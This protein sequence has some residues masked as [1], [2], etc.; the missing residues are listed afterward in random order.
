MADRRSYITD[1]VFQAIK[2]ND[3]LENLDFDADYVREFIV[4]NYFQRALAHLFAQG[5][6][7]A[8]R[9]K[10][11]AAGQLEIAGGGTIIDSYYYYYY[12]A[13]TS[14]V[15]QSFPTVVQRFFL[16]FPGSRG[17]FALSN[18]GV[19]YGDWISLPWDGFFQEDIQV[20]SFKI[21]LDG[22]TSFTAKVW[23]YY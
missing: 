22:A 15:E 18:D 21:D 13:Q 17:K 5:P 8:I 23:G 11:N 6:T 12:S 19:T 4:S 1:E 9:L 7:G 3:V 14:Q 20:K 2:N 16:E 10:C